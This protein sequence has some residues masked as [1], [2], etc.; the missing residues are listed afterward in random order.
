MNLLVDDLPSTVCD[1]P[2]RTDYRYMVILEQLLKDPDMTGTEKISAALDLLYIRQPAAS[3]KEAWD[4]LL[5]F[6]R[7]GEEP[8]DQREAASPRSGRT[9]YDF[10]QDAAYIYA[11]FRQVYGIDLQAGPL[12]WWAF[13]AML[14][15]LPESCL[16]GRIMGWRATDTRKLKGAEKRHIERMQRLF[17]IKGHSAGHTLTLAEQE[18]AY[19][20]WVDDRFRAAEEWKARKPVK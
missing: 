12:H 9:V 11:A 3:L 18:A 4:G 8:A 1:T 2:I 14:S 6:Y 15:S 16:M 13:R 17:A 20:A 7:C 19:K 5:W 10:D